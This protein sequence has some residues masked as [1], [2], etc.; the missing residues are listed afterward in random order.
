M[1]FREVL[2]E[3]EREES[4]RRLKRGRGGF[5]QRRFSFWRLLAGETFFFGRELGSP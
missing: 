3:R 5:E 1:L 4:E 2:R